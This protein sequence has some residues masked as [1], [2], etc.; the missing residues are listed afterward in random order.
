MRFTIVVGVMPCS[1]LKR[2]WSSRRRA[3][4]ASVSRIESVSLSAYRITEP[5]TLRAARPIVWISER[6]E[7]RK[8]SLSASRTATSATSGWT[9]WACAAAA[10]DDRKTSKV[11]GK[12]KRAKIKSAYKHTV[13]KLTKANTVVRGPKVTRADVSV[14]VT[15]KAG[16]KAGAYR[17]Y[18]GKKYLGTIKPKK[19]GAW[20]TGSVLTRGAKGR[21]HVVSASSKTVTLDHIAITRVP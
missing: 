20:H 21:V 5:F 6:V 10:V 19:K 4:S 1:S 13:T 8:P 16:K 11:H 15:T 12:I 3:V 7:R 9:R 2:A 14:Q 17:V 18:A